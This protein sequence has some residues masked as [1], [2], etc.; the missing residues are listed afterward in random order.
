MK[1]STTTNGSYNV[2]GSSSKT[3][4][5]D[6]FSQDVTPGGGFCKDPVRLSFSDG[7]L[8]RRRGELRHVSNSNLVNMKMEK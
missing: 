3:D 2:A 6:R 1:L 4:A 8:S 7:R 5:R